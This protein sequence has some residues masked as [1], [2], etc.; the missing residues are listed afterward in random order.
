MYDGCAGQLRRL[1]GL[2]AALPG[3]VTAQVMIPPILQ[4]SWHH[5]IAQAD[6]YLQGEVHQGT[7]DWIAILFKTLL[8]RG[9]AYTKALA[10]ALGLDH[11]TGGG[12]EYRKTALLPVIQVGRGWMRAPSGCTG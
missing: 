2:G 3:K 7:M 4:T 12:V 9:T 10:I 11:S 1:E 5:S 8:R 6:W